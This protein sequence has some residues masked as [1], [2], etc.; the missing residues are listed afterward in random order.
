MA[1]PAAGYEIRFVAGAGR[2]AELRNIETIVLFSGS[3][4]DILAFANGDDFAFGANGNDGIDGGG[5]DDYLAGEGGADDLRGGAGNDDIDGGSG[6]D[7]LHGGAGNDFLVGGTGVDA[8]FGEDGDDAGRLGDDSDSFAG[9][10]GTDTAIVA[11]QFAGFTARI[12]PDTE[13]L[14]I[15]SGTDTRFGAG[16]ALYDYNILFPDAPA[17]SSAILIVQATGLVAGEDLAFDGSAQQNGAFRIFAG[18]GVDRLTGGGDNDGFFFDAGANASLTGADRVDG[19]GGTDTIALRGPY[20]GSSAVAFQDGS[21]AN[22]EVLAFLT[23]HL[24]PHGGP[25]VAGGF[26]Y[27]VTMADGNVAAGA[28]MDIIGTTLGAD[29]SVVFDGRAESDGAFRIIL[30]AGDDTAWGG[31]GADLL[32]GGLGADRLDGGGGGDL[33]S[34]RD[35]AESTA[36]ATDT[37]ALGA[38]DRIDLSAID[39]SIAADGNQAFAYVGDAA[40]GHAAG[41]LRAVQAN[42]IWTVEA[43]VDGDGLADLVVTVATALAITA[44]SFIA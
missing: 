18:R 3:G 39:A 29:E 36:A 33:Y 10:A 6:D 2:S 22:V 17:G 35:V 13:V 23:G 31:E 14:L 34:Y 11:G 4:N 30:G 21:I 41:E 42:G 16:N 27:A 1:A 25:I 20:S 12:S 7:I 15:A 37:I 44:D 43:D 40:F 32:H 38:G 28:R 9:G 5:G 19:G 26:D 8:L 24:N